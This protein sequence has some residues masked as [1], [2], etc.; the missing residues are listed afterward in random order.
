MN[1][2]R[3]RFFLIFLLIIISGELFYLSHLH[4]F[5]EKDE[6][7]SSQWE[8][9]GQEMNKI[10][11]QKIDQQGAETAYMEFKETYASSNP[12]IAHGNAHI[13]GE[14]LYQKEGIDG[15]SVCDSS[16]A[17]GCYHSFLGTAIQSDGLKIV[18]TLNQKCI[19]NLKSQSLGCQHGIGH[20]ILA[21]L[22]YDFNSL[23][24]SLDYC[25]KLPANDPIGGCLGGAFMEFNFQTM[26]AQ[27]AQVRRLDLD[28]PYSPCSDL[29]QKYRMACYYWQAQWWSSV[30]SGENS[31]KYKRIGQYCLNLD[32]KEERQQCFLGVGNITAQNANWSVEEVIR[33]CNLLPDEEG[34]LSCRANAATSFLADEKYKDLAPQLCDNLDQNRKLTCIK[35]ANIK[36]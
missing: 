4:K 9:N 11:S 15:I 18:P 1:S 24:K 25:D 12:G 27:Q 2:S 13:F 29:Q 8:L 35:I 22:G 34:S 16:F 30:F 7:I 32:N 20:G 10:W 14:L 17:F 28:K 6:N 3:M 5:K 26:L 33:L 23:N 19:D 21:F 31:E 36:I